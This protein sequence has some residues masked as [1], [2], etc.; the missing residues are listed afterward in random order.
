MT[1]LIQQFQAI[2]GSLIL[3]V[4]FLLLWAIFN[5]IFLKFKGKIIRFPFELLFFTLITLI[6]FYFLIKVNDGKF[7]FY[8]LIFLL[9]GAGLCYKF[10]LGAFLMLLEKCLIKIKVKLAKIKIFKKIK[11]KISKLNWKKKLFT[12]KAKKKKKKDDSKNLNKKSD[13]LTFTFKK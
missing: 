8:F 12:K 9:V 3:G 11:T 10:Y 4:V 7:S 2:F 13:D 5:R 1:P 6:Y